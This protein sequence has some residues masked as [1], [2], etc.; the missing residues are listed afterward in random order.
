MSFVPLVAIPILPFVVMSFVPLVAVS[1]LPLMVKNL[2]PL[3]T[4]TAL[5]PIVVNRRLELT[6][7]PQ[8][9]WLVLN[10]ILL[11]LHSLLIIGL[12]V[13]ALVFVLTT[14]GTICRVFGTAV[15]LRLA[16]MPLCLL[17]AVL[18]FILV[19]L[20]A[21]MWHLIVMFLFV[22]RCPATLMCLLPLA[23]VRP[24][25]FLLGLPS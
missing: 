8:I 19:A 25:A 22:L 10:A 17:A 12:S 6:A 13:L 16:S 2:L 11:E 18:L 3:V 21:S 24:G 15:M 1:I 23:F 7:L 4:V 5:P 9:R 14:D 20:L